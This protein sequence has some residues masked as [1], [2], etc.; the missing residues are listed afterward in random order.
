MRAVVL[1]RGQATR[2]RAAASGEALTP[3]QV[4]AAG[5]GLKVL[6][7]VGDGSATGAFPARPFLDY[8]LGSLAD[9]GFEDVAIVV[10]PEHDRIQRRYTHDAPPSR[11]RVAF[12]IQREARGTADAV[13]ASESWAGDRPFVVVN[14]DNL[15]PADVLS[16]LGRLGAPGLA[17]FDREALGA[18]ADR[19]GDFA[20]VDIDDEGW[21]VRVVEK[22]GAAAVAARR[23]PL[24]SMNLWSFDGRIFDACR[25][26]P[27]SRRG[28][29][30]LPDAVGLAVSRGVRFHGIAG[31]GPVLDLSRRA[32]VETVSRQLA[33]A[34]P[35]P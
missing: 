19:A 15:Y 11:V 22:P 17:A 18:A 14:G 25:D 23:R 6:M 35:R 10:G 16:A 13:L 32:D 29:F 5:A 21:L 27:A 3:D 2:M 30:E 7:P 20:L 24:F 1:A 33:G 12:A 28:E 8:V 31:H 9:A 26:V 4:A 34:D